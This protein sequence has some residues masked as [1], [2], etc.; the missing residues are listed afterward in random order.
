MRAKGHNI[1]HYMR[2]CIIDPAH[3]VPG[4]MLLFPEAIYYA[5]NPDTLFNY[6]ETQHMSTGAF[7][8]IYGFEYNTDWSDINSDTYDYVCIVFPLYDAFTKDPRFFKQKANTMITHIYDIIR[9]N[10]FKKVCLFDVYDY[11]YDPSLFPN[12]PVDIFFKRNFSKHKQYATHVL[13]FPVQMF[14]TPCVLWTMVKY[15]NSYV[16]RDIAKRKDVF[17]A[18]SIYTHTDN[19]YGIIR[20]RHAVFN[21]IKNDI[22]TYSVPKHTFIETLSSFAICVDL[23]GVGD[24]NKRTFEIFSS[25]SLWM[26]NMSDL[27][28]NFTDGD[29]FHPLCYFSNKEEFIKNKTTLLLH[30]DIYRDA[31]IK[32]EHIIRKY[33]TKDVLRKYIIESARFLLM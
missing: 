26:S 3:H 16:A 4:L 2:L 31:V 20:D 9:Q 27:N 30:E 12:Q 24:P 5:H 14:C 8:Y 25:G 7:K 33:F 28:W 6:H 21:D 19:T 18:G 1:Y 11:D 29:A 22:V 32:Q 10:K 13:P 15:A 23:V 17:W